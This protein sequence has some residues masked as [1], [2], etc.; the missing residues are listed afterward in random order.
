MLKG[1]GLHEVAMTL[2]TAS[3]S[4]LSIRLA[5]ITPPNKPPEGTGN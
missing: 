1:W 3:F 2:S 5:S 4:A